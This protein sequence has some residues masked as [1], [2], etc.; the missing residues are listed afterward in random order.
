MKWT[1]I[2]EAQSMKLANVDID[3]QEQDCNVTLIT[4]TDGV[5]TYRIAKADYGDGLKVFEPSKPEMVKKHRL[6]GNYLDRIPYDKSFD[7]YS[8]A[9]DER[10]NLA[11]EV[12][13]DIENIGLVLIEIEVEKE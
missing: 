6:H 5:N 4:L 8:D 2:E 7:N 11:N 1:K 10:R 3:I 12:A 9:V 13:R